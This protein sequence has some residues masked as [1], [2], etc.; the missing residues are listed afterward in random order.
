[1]TAVLA[2]SINSTSEPLTFDSAPARAAEFL[3]SIPAYP[4]GFEGRGIVI[5]AGGVRY[6][7]CCWVLVNILRR[8]GCK[9]PIEVWHLGEDEIDANWIKLVEPLGVTCIDAHEVRRR[10]PHPRLGGWESKS[11]AILHSRFEEVLFLD[12]DNVPAVDPTFLFDTPEYRATGT[13]FWPDCNRTNPHQAAW[14]LFDV[15]Y[16]DEWEQESGQLLINKRRSW[17]TLNLCNWYNSHSDLVYQFLYGDKDT[18]RLAWH[19]VGTSFAMP[20]RIPWAS[21]VLRQGDFDGNLLFQHRHGDKW[22]FAGNRKVAGF[23]HQEECAALVQEL[24]ERWPVIRH[25]AGT[26]SEE[27]H[28]LGA[29]LA[30]QDFQFVRLGYNRWP[31]QLSASGLLRRGRSKRTFFWWLKNRQIVLAGADGRVYYRLTQN[32]DGSWHGASQPPVAMRVRLIRR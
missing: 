29:E 26:I 8:V 2:D 13:I 16:R 18:F 27:D 19:R 6:L 12:A 4:G 10:H 11:Y 3:A 28:A 20:P 31:M 7:T 9:L 23:R 1:M 14:R 21:V 24:L 15:P 5:S 17:S 22:S 30:A 25:L 32:G